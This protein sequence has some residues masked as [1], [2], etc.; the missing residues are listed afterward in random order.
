MIL[1]KA[2]TRRTLIKAGAVVA[3][4]ASVLI[5][6]PPAFAKDDSDLEARR[7]KMLAD[8]EAKKRRLI[9]GW[10]T[11]N[12]WPA[13]NL[14][15]AGGGIWTRDVPGTDVVLTVRDGEPRALFE[16]VVQRFHLEIRALGADD[17]VGFDPKARG[18]KPR[19]NLASGTAIDV[20]P[21]SYPPGAKN[22]MFE[23]EVRAVRDIL[24]ACDGLLAW[25]GDERP[26]AQG[27]FY[28]TAGPDSHA[29]AAW[30]NRRAKAH[31][32]LGASGAGNS[33]GA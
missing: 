20:L 23:Q 24:A 21:G 11:P 16:Y 30:V 26:L 3:A 12:G 13:E 18:A 17:V 7:Q 15:N 6:S 27:F 4:G 1:K 28:L 8:A 10:N 33:L 22:G 31:E 32:R 29:L 9:P 19:T 5:A 14:S 25:G 2:V